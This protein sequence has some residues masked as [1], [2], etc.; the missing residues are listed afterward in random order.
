MGGGGGKENTG[1]NKDLEI[2]KMVGEWRAE[3][4]RDKERKKHVKQK[5]RDRKK[6]REIWEKKVQ[7]THEQSQQLLRG[8]QA[9]NKYLNKILGDTFYKNEGFL[10]PPLVIS[11]TK[12]PVCLMPTPPK[13]MFCL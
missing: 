11:W 12:K 8:Q 6:K 7:K 10:D 1:T 5:K 3:V 2:R 9:N 4:D 13:S